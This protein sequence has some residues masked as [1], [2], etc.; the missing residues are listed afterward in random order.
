MQVKVKVSRGCYNEL[1]LQ[2]GIVNKGKEHVEVVDKVRIYYTF[3]PNGT[4]IVFTDCSNN[5]FQ[6]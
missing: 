5:P 2:E 1:D 4:V 3:Y 6:V